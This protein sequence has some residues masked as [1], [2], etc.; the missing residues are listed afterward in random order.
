MSI[1]RWFYKESCSS[2]A[3]TPFQIFDGMHLSRDCRIHISRFCKENMFHHLIIEMICE[4]PDREENLLETVRFYQK[5]DGNTDWDK[6]FRTKLAEHTDAYEQCS[7]VEA[8]LIIVNSSPNPVFHAVTARGVCGAIQSCILGVLAHPLIKEQEFYFT[9]HGESEFNILGRIGGNADL[10]SRG[11]KY[12]ERLTKYLSGL[13]SS[14]SGA[15]KPKLIWTSELQRTISTARNVP[16]ANRTCLKELNEIDAG[17]CEGLTYEEIHE[18]F[19]QEFAWRDQDKLK[20]RYPHGESYLDLLQRVDSVVQGLFT[21][22]E[23]LLVSHQAVLR[24]IMAFFHGTKPGEFHLTFLVFASPLLTTSRM[25]V[26][27]RTSRT[28]M[29]PFTRC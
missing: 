20:Y 15:K 1:F 5:S 27:Q 21:M 12:A 4:A 8:P 25:A 13:G 29:C 22:S 10:T 3:N 18:R 6:V 16:T 19:P 28:L 9:R 26:L 7:A 23:V 2:E 14:G 11:L 17:I 24:C